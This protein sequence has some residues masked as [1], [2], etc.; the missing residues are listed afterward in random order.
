MRAVR[1]ELER[2]PEEQRG[3]HRSCSPERNA[4]LPAGTTMAEILERLCRL[5][6]RPREH[7]TW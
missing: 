2:I 3:L 6:E 1:A 4:N 7:E 5:T